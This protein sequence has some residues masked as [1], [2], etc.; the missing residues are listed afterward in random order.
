MRK[1]TSH[2]LIT[3]GPIEERVDEKIEGRGGD[4]QLSS[5]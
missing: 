4:V 2:V 3:L 5:F 1:V